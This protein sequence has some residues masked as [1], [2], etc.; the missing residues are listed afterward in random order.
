M[1]KLTIFLILVS[2]KGLIENINIFLIGGKGINLGSFIFPL[3]I[4]VLYEGNKKHIKMVA[5]IWFMI[6][7]AGLIIFLNRM[8]A[9]NFIAVV[10]PLLF[11]IFFAKRG[12]EEVSTLLLT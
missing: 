8:N 7:I 9:E 11:S 6:A 10:C 5:G 3:S 1:K 4:A 12:K 2:I